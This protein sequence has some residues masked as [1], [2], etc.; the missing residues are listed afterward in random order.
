MKNEE[1]KKYIQNQLL[2]SKDRLEG[3]IRDV[4][5]KVFHKRSAY[6]VLENHINSFINGK[7]EPRI[8]VMPGLRGT[9]KTTLL[10]Q[11]YFHA[12]A[13]KLYLSVDE[14][15]KRFDVTLWDA[16]ECYEELV[17]SAVEEFK[18]PFFLFLDEVHYDKKWSAFLKTLYDKSKNVFVLC[19]GSASL[20]LKDQIN[21]DL[22]RR[23]KLVDIFPINFHE[24]EMIKDNILLPENL[25][26]NIAN[27]LLSSDNAEKLFKELKKEEGRVKKYWLQIDRFEIKK[28]MKFG[29]LPFTI[30][31]EN[32]ALSNEYI[33]QMID[34]IISFDL[35]LLGR[36]EVETISKV[37]RILYLISDSISVSL[38]H[39]SCAVEM[40][41][42]TLSS[43]LMALCK[44]GVLIRVAPHGSHYSQ[45][46][47]P[48]KYLF[49]T[50]AFRSFF[51]NS[52]DSSKLLDDYQGSLFE[53]LAVLCF[54]RFIPKYG[55]FSLSYDSSDGGADF[56]LGFPRKKI[57]IE[58]AAGNKGIKQA[59]FTM[60][61]KKCDYG[62]IFCSEELYFDKEQ[63]I[64]KVPWQYVLL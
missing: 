27:A 36:F 58:V 9:G 12:Q 5:G 53:D 14:I 43:V 3:Y 23:V 54:Q 63:N 30:Q 8:I 21:A 47:K 62:V 18:K 40:R 10:A 52:L 32:E 37:E 29:T 38:T 11:L 41:K 34:K 13:E 24:Y 31:S 20:L 7:N 17:G 42:E 25:S 16:I 44:A 22:S 61:K 28:Y 35:P 56:I 50:P 45:V 55:D 1:L 59:L 26:E 15:V 33:G 57:A 51:L 39:L 64:V 4:N 19:T 60:D 6:F 48:S 49:A 2:H 46:R